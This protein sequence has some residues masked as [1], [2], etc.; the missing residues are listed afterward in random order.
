MSQHDAEG[1]EAKEFEAEEFEAK[2][3]VA[4]EWEA[5]VVDSEDSSAASGQSPQLEPEAAEPDE[6]ES[7]KR[8]Y[9]PG[10]VMKK[11]GCIGCGGMILALPLLVGAIAILVFAVH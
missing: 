5:N 3:E 1:F 2:V 7:K 6:T 4:K 8:Y 9:N 11:K 10:E